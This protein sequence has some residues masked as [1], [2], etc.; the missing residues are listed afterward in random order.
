MRQRIRVVGIVRRQDEVL[1]LKRVLGRA[2]IVPTWEL[3]TGKLGQGEQPEESIARVIFD[4]TGASIE[5]AK[6]R[7]VVTISTRVGT[8]ITNSLYII[9]DIYLKEGEKL[10]AGKK[11]TAYKFLRSDDPQITS[12]MQL[13]EASRTIMDI[14]MGHTAKPIYDGVTQNMLGGN[15]TM[16]TV[17]IDGGSRGNPGPSGIGYHIVGS[18]GTPI[19]SGGEFIG[20]ATSRVAEYYA[21]REGAEQAIQLGIKSVR[22]V[23]DSL[24]LVNQMNGLYKVK[25]KDVMPIYNSIREQLSNFDTVAFIHVKRE[26]NKEADRQVNLA[27]NKHFD[28]DENVILSHDEA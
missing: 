4:Y 9:Y 22:F 8:E 5:N 13:T 27:I 14:E 7:D 15:F 19:K 10:Q 12:Q 2:E 11:Y 20:F 24:M 18:D 3:P 25:N 1:L 17:Y 21:L 23:S 28:L 6:L 26:L 16:A